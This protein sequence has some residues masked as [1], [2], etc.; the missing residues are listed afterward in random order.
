MREMLPLWGQL[1]AETHCQPKCILIFRNPMEVADSLQKRDG[2][3][4]ARAYLLW[5]GSVIEAERNSRHLPRAFTLYD[6]LLSDWR[7]EVA[8]IGS[9]LD[10]NWPVSPDQVAGAVE[11][12]IHPSSR[13]HHVEDQTFLADERIPQQVRDLYA[14]VVAAVES[15]DAGNLS[16]HID[17]LT[18]DRDSSQ[19][20]LRQF[21]QDLETET[22]EKVIAHNVVTMDFHKQI[23]QYHHAALAAGEQ[24]TARD[25]QLIKY[26]HAAVAAGGEITG[27]IIS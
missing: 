19:S 20:L 6:R 24:I 27:A 12:F 15:G 21:V 18:T 23:A 11:E 13:H 8:S 3:T 2:I 22:R 7:H 10:I 14:A 4:H 5:L 25:E 26:H 9:A 16:K 1:L 17:E